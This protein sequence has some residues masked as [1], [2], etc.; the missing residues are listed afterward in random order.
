MKK[1]LRTE[2]MVSEEVLTDLM[3]DIDASLLNDNYMEQDLERKRLAWIKTFLR[4]KNW[5][6]GKEPREKKAFSW[7]KEKNESPLFYGWGEAVRT[8]M[9]GKLRAG[10]S[11]V[12]RK[13]AAFS[14]FMYGVLTMAVVA[15]GFF[16][17]AEKRRRIG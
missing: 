5:Q 4:E 14:G 1:E 3:S 12:K 10:M 9:G 15:I 16:A 11:N 13:A 2:E 7:R 8:D 6:K 17:L